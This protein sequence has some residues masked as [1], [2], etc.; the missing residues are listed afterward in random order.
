MVLQRI[1]ENWPIIKRT[2]CMKPQVGIYS[3][4]IDNS[5]NYYI[6][7]ENI[8]KNK[9]GFSGTLSYLFNHFSAKDVP[10]SEILKQLN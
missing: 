7:G 5:L 2:I 9:R 10:F 1:E 4:F 6:F 3:G 8:T